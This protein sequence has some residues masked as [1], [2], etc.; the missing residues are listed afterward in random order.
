MLHHRLSKGLALATSLALVGA[1]AGAQQTPGWVLAEQKISR[2]T[3]GA[4]FHIDE[5]DQFGRSVISLGD[6]DGDGVGDIA[7]GAHHDDDGGTNGLSSN[8]GAVWVLFLNPDG[9]VKERSKISQTRG[10]F[11]GPLSHQDQFGRSMGNIGDF[12]GDGVTDIAVGAAFDDDGGVRR[13]AVWLLYLNPDGTVKDQR[14]ISS[15]AGG[16]SG[17]LDDD[18][19]FGRAVISLGDLDGDGVTDLAVGAAYDD[20]GGT[21]GFASNV[22]A[23]WIL[24][25]NAD[26]TV[27]SE[28]KISATAGSFG[29]FP[30]NYANFGLCLANI[31]DLDGDGVVDLAVG[32]P[33][34]R[35]GGVRHGALWILFLRDDGTVKGKQKISDFE[36][37]FLAPINYGSEF[38]TSVS[39]LGDIDGDGVVD[40][41]VGTILDD[42]VPNDRGAVHILFMNQ[43]GTVKDYQKINSVQ[44][45]FTSQL[46]DEDWF[47][48]AVAGLG[49]LDGDG[50]ADLVVGARFDDDG[51]P[52]RGAVYVLFLD[53]VTSERILT[54]GDMVFYGCGLNPE[55]SLSVLAGDPSLGGTLTLG[56][57]NP[58]GTQAPGANASLVLS[59]APHRQH[60]CGAISA[61]RGM[62]GPG[63]VLI[64]LAGGNRLRPNLSGPPWAG[65]GIPSPVDIPIPNDPA[66]AGI[67][68]YAQGFLFD[69]TAAPGNRMGLTTALEF[70]LGP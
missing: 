16:F 21:S 54:Q 8:L 41:A 20:D 70:V 30:G 52:N 57:D 37:N 34:D 47:G 67:P 4:D 15:T 7:V 39:S 27:R 19:Q 10:N 50:K 69:R 46:D 49:D 33:K 42:E 53:G 1:S 38:G 3:G 65:P 13:G 40:L 32:E 23:V 24:F 6:L 56:L 29:A 36:G 2:L 18:D 48:S 62:N 22:G 58:L 12:D 28:Q 64:S 14:K 55:S 60:P 66:I 61:S 11:L 17:V 9:T 25:M 45:G 5:G 51:G 44:G 43:D 31:G 59:L 63:E 68:V 35:D 26:G